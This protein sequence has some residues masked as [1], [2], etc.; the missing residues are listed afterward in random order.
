MIDDILLTFDGNLRRI[1]RL[2]E[3]YATLGAGPGRRSTYQIEVLR[4]AVVL[5]HATLEDYLRNLL[6]WKLPTGSVE[7]LNK[8]GLAGSEDA[9]STKF[10]L[11]QLL[12]YPTLSVREIIDRSIEQH[13]N[14][15]SFNKVSDISNCL[16]DVG[17]ELPAR[18]SD[19]L[20]PELGGMMNR[21]HHIVHQADRNEQIGSGLHRYRS[22]SVHQVEKW[23]ASVDRLVLETSSLLR[24]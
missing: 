13:L 14:M 5:L 9:H 11:G 2:L 1:N 3:L 23:K 18:L 24:V 19:R 20:F 21:R 7:R 17:I 6:R 22:L 4:A 16:R 15:T 8:I 12:K 10:Q